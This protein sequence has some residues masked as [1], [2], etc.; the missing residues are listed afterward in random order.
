MSTIQF[1]DQCYPP[2]QLGTPKQLDSLWN[3][4]LNDFT[5]DGSSSFTLG[6]GNAAFDEAALQSPVEVMHGENDNNDQSHHKVWFYLDCFLGRD[7]PGVRSIV[8][9]P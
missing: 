2:N 5:E 3:R 8:P 9:E 4:T 1:S 6:I 7:S